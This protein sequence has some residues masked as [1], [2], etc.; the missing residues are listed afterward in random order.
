[1]AKKCAVLLKND[2]ILPLEGAKKVTVIGELAR[3]M[4]FQGGGSS[5]IN[6]PEYKNAIKAF[7]EL[8]IEVEFAAGYH[9]KDDIAEIALE[10]EAEDVARVAA[11][12]GRPV[13]FFGGLTDIAEG[14]G[15]DRTTLAMPQNQVRLFDKIYA[16]NDNIIYVSFSGAPYTVPFAT[17]VRAMLHM[18][19]CG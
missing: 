8:G 3:T 10:M 9:V 2:G 11:K 4:R 6:V 12:E 15:Y 16:A 13:L 5:H 7:E 14:E 18:N 1:M 17:K 19:L